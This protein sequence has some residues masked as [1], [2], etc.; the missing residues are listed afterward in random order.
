MSIN[1]NYVIMHAGR[2][3][4]AVEG[5]GP[6]MAARLLRLWVRIPPGAWMFVCCECCVLSGLCDELITRPEESYRLWC[7]IVC[8][9]DNLVNEAMTRIGSQHHSKKKKKVIMHAWMLQQ[10]N[11]RAFCPYFASFFHLALD[12]TKINFITHIVP[13]QYTLQ[14][15]TE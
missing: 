1:E 9:L 7:V 5:V 10:E 3:G 11:L 13:L 2:S 12:F 4:S 8:D 6:S 15:A 14:S